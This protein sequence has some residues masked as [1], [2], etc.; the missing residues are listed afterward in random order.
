[1]VVFLLMILLNGVPVYQDDYPYPSLRACRDEGW[2][3]VREY[4]KDHVRAQFTCEETS[5]SPEG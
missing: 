4:Q 3:L 1:M 2:R 5:I